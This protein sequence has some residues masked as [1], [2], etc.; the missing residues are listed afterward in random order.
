MTPAA[1]ASCALC[2]LPAGSKPYGGTFSGEEKRFCCA[3]CLNVYS[4]LIESGVIAEGV[5]FRQTELYQQSLRLG[6]ISNGAAESS[7][8]P[9]DAER[10]ERLYHLSGLWCTSCGWLIEHALSRERGIASAEVL[11]ASDLLK[12]TYC[13]QYIEP[14]RIPARVASLGYKAAEY[15]PEHEEDRS[16]WNDLLL[17]LGV[18]GMLWMNVMLFSLVVYTSYFEGIAM[19]A[20]RF[21][22]LILMF[23]ATPAVFYSGWPL[24]RIGVYG[25]LQG[26]IRMEA[27]IATGILAAYGYSTAQ[28]FLGGQHYYFDTACAIV[29]LVLAGKAMERAAKEKTARAIGMLH[30][31]LPRK[32]R[33][34]QDGRERFVAVEALQAGMTML[35]KPGERV[36]A[37]GII[38]AG[39]SLL[40]ESVL[41]GESAPRPRS[42]GDPVASGSLNGAGVLEV[43]IT[44]AGEATIL[45]Q[46]VRAVEQALASRTEIERTVDR[47]SRFFVPTVLLV[48]VATFA[49]AVALGVPVTDSLLRS[50]AVVV[51]ACPCAL[52]I[53]TPLAVTAA[54]GMASRH[55]ILIRD[56][57]I[58]EALPTIDVLVLDKTGTVTEGNF[59]VQESAGDPPLDLLAALE[60]RSEHPLASAIV[61][62]ANS[63]AGSL[64]A[65]TEIEVH[66]GLGIVGT[67]D[68]HRIAAGSLGLL[69]N[70]HI[71]PADAARAEATAW[72]AE[73]LTVVW[74]AVDGEC[75]GALALGDRLREEAGA[76]IE[77]MR[78]RG[79]R[80]MLLSGDSQEAVAKLASVLGI[81]EFRAAVTPEG[82]AD[83]IRQLRGEGRAVAMA[84]DGINDAPALAAATLGIAM[85]SGTDLAVQAAPV[86]LMSRSLLRVAD[87]F[88][89]AR[90]TLRT[91]RQNLFWAF[92]YNVAGIALAATGV[93]NPILAAGAM[94]LSSL[95]VILNSY[96]LGV[97]VQWSEQAS[98][99]RP[100]HQEAEP[101]VAA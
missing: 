34:I 20:S 11:F 21:V 39:N 71:T 24:L 97:R 47:V 86:V 4:I 75:R 63:P 93:L 12:V 52:G 16:E 96:R 23:L 70:L 15:S 90:H 74:C 81:E 30:R 41:T 6:L 79:V 77:T 31:L 57:L 9:A 68:G 14:A 40:D 54:V 3:G 53:A 2:G 29:T 101:T 62:H 89:L 58:L 80:T 83:V 78:R 10:R 56:A 69:Q 46:V 42:A 1:A 61:K 92:C 88:D 95:S 8:I 33:L 17:R 27:L 35:V 91:V 76:L 65:V 48:A 5:D 37:D 59:R 43:E 64:P 55:G 50:I 7:G 94:A 67:V 13:P 99:T 28:A 100:D 44:R 66:R 38:R 82:K 72:A 45:S 60:S 18:A 32:A 51:I 19:W 22:P 26:S 84:G 73:G 25:L 36:A 85:G 87:I 98:P 49:G